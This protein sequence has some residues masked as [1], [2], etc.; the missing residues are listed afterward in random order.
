[1]SAPGKSMGALDWS[2][3]HRR[4]E[5]IRQ[6]IEHGGTLTQEE[7]KKVLHDRAEG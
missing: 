1:M 4:L 2:E 3:I 7:K 5:A 6:T